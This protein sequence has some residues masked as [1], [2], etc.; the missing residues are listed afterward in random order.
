[1]IYHFS[2]QLNLFYTMEIMFLLIFIGIAISSFIILRKQMNTSKANIDSQK[3][4][5]ALE[6]LNSFLSRNII[7][8]YFGTSPIILRKDEYLVICSDAQYYEER[9]VRN[10]YGGSFRVTKGFLFAFGTI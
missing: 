7:P 6:Y 2:K 5:K 9:S 4:A 10:Y 8:I 3:S 1:M